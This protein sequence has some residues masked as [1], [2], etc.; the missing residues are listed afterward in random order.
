MLY[1]LVE[2]CSVVCF[3]LWLMHLLVPLVAGLALSS[4]V[5]TFQHNGA[6]KEDALKK[7]EHVF[8]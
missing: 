5:D 7:F 8:R 3:D 2:L 4:Y 1:D 6:W